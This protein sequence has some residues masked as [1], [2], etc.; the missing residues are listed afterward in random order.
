MGAD[1][2]DHSF[3][4]PLL[5]VLILSLTAFR[6]LAASQTGLLP[7]EAYYWLWS[8]SPQ[9][10]YYDHPP[11]IAWWIWFSSAVFGQSA[12]AIRLLPVLSAAA[13]T[14]LTYAVA[15]ETG[16]DRRLSAMAG[17]LL[18]AT[19]MFGLNAA[20]A[21]PD[22]P[23]ITFWLLALWA[24]ARLRR[25]GTLSLWLLVG[26]FAGLG[27]VSKYTNFFLGPGICLCIAVDRD[28]R[29][30]CSVAWIAA[31]LLV[32]AATFAPVFLWNMHNDWVSFI[33]Q[34]GRIGAVGAKGWYLPE[35]VATQFALINPLIAGLATLGLIRML[36]AAKHA[37]RRPVLFLMSTSVPLAAYM[38]LHSLH[39]RVQGNWLLP[40]YPTLAILAALALKQSSNQGVILTRLALLFGIGATL[41]VN[42]YMASPLAGTL[43][44]R[45]PADGAVGWQALAERIHIIAKRHD[46]GWIG[47]AN[48]GVTAELTYHLPDGVRVVDVVEP[49]RYSFEGPARPLGDRLGLLV[50]RAR[51]AQPEALA[52]CFGSMER[53]ET[54][55]RY[56]DWRELETYHVIRV[57][58]PVPSLVSSGCKSN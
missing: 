35:F 56:A 30:R 38:M 15:R 22:A 26:L 52:Q 3:F 10:G 54:I 19:V 51:D 31:G 1:R 2:N 40:A 33:K 4:P 7:D 12:F 29:A 8:R 46:A 32:A 39:D 44:L 9:A 16:L 20:V 23:A 18:N 42:L 34:F 57:E 58:N 50:L 43:P 27:C 25:T 45:S 17:L 49:V 11:M 55:G 13:D 37:L 14:L 28:F 47:T 5:L 21:T 41:A 53:I 36:P 48:Y 6:L 24:L